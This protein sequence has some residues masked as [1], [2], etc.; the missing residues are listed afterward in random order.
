MADKPR[1]EFI[2]LTTS[3]LVDA[4]LYGTA[5]EATHF[6]HTLR[7]ARAET[8]ADDGARLERALGESHE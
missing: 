3:L 5:E 8:K 2:E 7:A 1:T 4:V 6:A